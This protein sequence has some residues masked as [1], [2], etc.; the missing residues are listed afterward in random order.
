MKRPGLVTCRRGDGVGVQGRGGGWAGV[1]ANCVEGEA[2]E[3]G[4]GFL[5][6]SSSSLG[7][8]RIHALSGFPYHPPQ[9]VF[10]PSLWFQ[11]K[12]RKM[13]PGGGKGEMLPLHVANHTKT[14]VPIVSVGIPIHM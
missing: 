10:L 5:Q 3:A 14:G 4:L 13:L 2:W 12:S 11:N 9:F 1:S 8:G 6:V 7:K